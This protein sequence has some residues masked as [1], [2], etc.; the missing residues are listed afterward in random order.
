MEVPMIF[1]VPHSNSCPQRK[2]PTDAC[3]CSI[4]ARARLARLRD[5]Y[6]DGNHP[7]FEVLSPIDP[8]GKWPARAP[9]GAK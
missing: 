2:V 9:G 6:P 1:D 4:E 5:Q 3:S 7:G 8:E